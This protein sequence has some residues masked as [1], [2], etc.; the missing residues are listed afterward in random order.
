[1]RALLP[2][3]VCLLAACNC[4]TT[5]EQTN[6]A[7]RGVVVYSLQGNSF[8]TSRPGEYSS[9]GGDDRLP[10]LVLANAGTG[11]SLR[12]HQSGTGTAIQAVADRN[13]EDKPALDVSSSGPGP[14]AR[15]TGGRIALGPGSTVV[16]ESITRLPAAD[17]LVVDAP[18]SVIV[19]EPRPGA[20]R[21]TL[22]LPEPTEGQLLW[23]LNDDD[24]AVSV[25]NESIPPGD[26]RQLLF[27]T[28]R[29]RSVP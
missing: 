17:R 9:G 1:M 8:E 25:G 14:T 21:N 22:I 24:D 18:A 4:E 29:F 5:A 6:R 15:F 28:G 2:T 20:Q 11:A 26:L 16:V 10:V 23:V 19:V 27:L 3:A 13:A 12:A 7:D